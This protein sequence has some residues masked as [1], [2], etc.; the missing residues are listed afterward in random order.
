MPCF[1]EFLVLKHKIRFLCLLPPRWPLN[2]YKFKLLEYL[3]AFSVE[4]KIQYHIWDGDRMHIR[5]SLYQIVGKHN[6]T[7]TDSPTIQIGE[8]ESDHLLRTFLWQVLR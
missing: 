6:S 4:T 3:L 2:S 5:S 8:S 7:C 1:F